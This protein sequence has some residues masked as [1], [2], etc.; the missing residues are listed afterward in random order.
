MGAARRLRAALQLTVLYDGWCPT[1]T[2]SVRW[3]KRLDL[4]SLAQFVSFR[5]PGVL[6]QYPAGPGGAEPRR[7]GGGGASWEPRCG[8]ASNSPRAPAARWAGGGAS[9]GP[10]RPPPS[11][12]ASASVSSAT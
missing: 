12:P 10:P 7:A 8:P 5:D 6:G 3:L 9:S 11:T 2:R 4:F 1:C